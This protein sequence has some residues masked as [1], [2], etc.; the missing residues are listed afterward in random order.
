MSPVQVPEQTAF[1]RA[2]QHVD[3]LRFLVRWIVW[4]VPL[5]IVVGAACAGFLWALDAVTLLRFEHPWLVWLLPAAGAASAGMYLRFGQN[6]ER[7]SN[8]I[9]EEIHQPKEGIP[10]RMAPLVLLG[11]LITHLFGGSAGREG[12]AV[13]MGGSLAGF[14]NRIPGFRRA[15]SSFM[16]SA[17]MAAGFAGVFGTPFAGTIFA[18]EVLTIGRMNLTAFVP[19]LI[20]A[21]VSDRTCLILGGTHTPYSIASPA[22]SSHF[23]GSAA[24]LSLLIKCVLV[25]IVFG[26]VSQ[27]F[28]Q[29]THL[30]HAL[31]RRIPGP[32]WLRPAAGGIVVL[33]LWW[34]AGRSDYL[35]LGVLSG[36]DSTITISSAFTGTEPSPFS[37]L[38]KLIFTATTVGSG[39]KGGEVT[40]L[41]YVGATLGNALSGPMEAPADLFAGLGFVAVFAGATNTPLACTIMAIELFGS[42]YLATFAIACATA[43]L[44]SGSAGLYSAQRVSPKHDG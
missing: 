9:L 33:V 13:Q 20:A 25:S 17:G 14:L 42:D 29:T 41:F 40:P 11:T 31:C 1:R 28:V 43:W 34:I 36:P 15:N 24:D 6:V 19:C 44:F 4:T 8:L 12:T 30:V 5:G 21:V 35:G 37:W 23:V 39:F 18:M 2:R 7:G 38:W 16:L 10:L 22:T 3:S 26:L 32:V 27:L